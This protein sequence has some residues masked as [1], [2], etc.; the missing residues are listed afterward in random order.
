VAAVGG[1]GAAAW[2][3]EEGQSQRAQ[4]NSQQQLAA[5]LKASQAAQLKG[6]LEHAR[7]LARVQTEAASAQAANARL[8]SAAIEHARELAQLRGEIAKLKRARM[9]ASAADAGDADGGGGA[10]AAGGSGGAS[11][12]GSASGGQQQQQQQLRASHHQVLHQVKQEKAD[13]GE[14]LADKDEL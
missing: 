14:Q 13:V 7:E 12:G 10:G 2:R 5:L 1:A 8:R 9:H 11:G 4:H 3:T 6:V